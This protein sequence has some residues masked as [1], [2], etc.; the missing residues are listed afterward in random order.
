MIAKKRSPVAIAA[1]APAATSAV[2]ENNEEEMEEDFDSD[3]D[4][5]E[6]MPELNENMEQA[7][8]IE[9]ENCNLWI[10]QHVE[11][12]KF[13]TDKSSSMTEADDLKKE[14]KTIHGRFLHVDPLKWFQESPAAKQEQF[15]PI[16]ILASCHLARADSGA[17]QESVFSSAGVNMSTRQTKMLPERY[18]KKVIIHHNIKFV[19]KYIYKI[20]E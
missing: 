14:L 20:S 11:W 5:I 4:I 19:E 8:S 6:A 10:N 1:E 2:Q 18:A 9:R 3:D 7:L 15:A 16:C 17:F 12:N 13:L